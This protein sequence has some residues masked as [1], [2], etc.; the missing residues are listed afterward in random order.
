MASA[1]GVPL[2]PP[3]LG[4]VPGVVGGVPGVDGLFGGAALRGA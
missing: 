4:G 2:L 3:V 1:Y